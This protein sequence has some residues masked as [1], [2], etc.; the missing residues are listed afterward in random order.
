MQQQDA[1]VGHGR[2][3]LACLS[4]KLQRAFCRMQAAGLGQQ[5]QP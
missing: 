2:Q 1:C 5:A 3:R 4:D